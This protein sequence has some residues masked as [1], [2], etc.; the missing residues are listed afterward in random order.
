MHLLPDEQTALYL[1]K[2]STAAEQTGHLLPEQLAV[3]YK[4]KWFKLFVP[5]YFGGLGADL[6]SGLRLEE[7]L[8]KI[9]GSL[10]WTVTLCSGASMFVGY[11]ENS[12]SREVFSNEKVCFAGSGHASGIAKVTNNGYIVNGNWH[13]ATGTPHA[14]IFTA[15]CTIEENGKL[16]T[17]EKGE[18]V[19]RSFFFKKEE[20]KTFIDWDAMGLKATASD[21][22]SVKD[23]SVPD[24]RCFL[25]DVNHTTID[26]PLYTYPFLQFAEAT[27]AVNY[28]GMAQHFLDEC[29]VIFKTIEV[30]DVQRNAVLSIYQQKEDELLLLKQEFYET[31]N[32][33]WW[34]HL[35][36]YNDKG[37]KLQ[38]VSAVS[39][40]MVTAIKHIITDLYSFCGLSQTKP[41]STINR[42]WRDI[43][44][45][46]QH[47][48]LN[49]PQV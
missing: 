49:I 33:S 7:A 31:V 12:I 13:Y 47:R 22:F 16:I 36:Q 20:V 6:I 35:E 1:K 9:D 30:T 44:T 29:G 28:L 19:I 46:S 21:S 14:T 15:N 23:I 40:K 45:A 10:G 37:V 41:S 4:E 8:A 25:I 26:H 39:K 38:Q 42:I 34:H 18:P 2:F 24:D 17:D 27:L 11:L 32:E 48:L 5:E 43:F 3:I